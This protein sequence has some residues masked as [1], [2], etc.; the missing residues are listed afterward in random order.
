M[1][2]SERQLA[3]GFLRSEINI[4]NNNNNNNSTTEVKMF[5]I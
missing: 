1:D 2:R 3:K 5:V 4:N